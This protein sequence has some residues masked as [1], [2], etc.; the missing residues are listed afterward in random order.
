[1]NSRAAVEGNKLQLS[2]KVR[3]LCINKHGS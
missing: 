1:M 2:D 3:N